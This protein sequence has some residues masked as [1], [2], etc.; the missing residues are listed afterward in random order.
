MTP[1]QE[2]LLDYG[3][4]QLAAGESLETVMAGLRADDAAEILPLLQ[5]VQRIQGLQ[6]AP[7]PAA[8]QRSME[9]MMTERVRLEKVRKSPLEMMRQRG[10]V[11][12]AAMSMVL[13]AVLGLSGLAAGALTLGGMQS[14]QRL[15]GA[16]PSE[17]VR[18]PNGEATL[19]SEMARVG[20]EELGQ[21]LRT[22]AVTGVVFEG[23]VEALDG[24]VWQVAG[25][26]VRL[27]DETEIV[28]GAVAVGAVVDI[29][30][31]TQAEGY[32]LATR[33]TVLTVA[34]VVTPTA[35]PAPTL[36]AMPEAT[37][38]P[39]VTATPVVTE[40]A[41]SVVVGPTA[42]ASETEGP[43]DNGG[44]NSGPGGGSDDDD[45]D[46]AGDDDDDN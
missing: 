25:V 29:E 36:T 10:W 3:L 32:V 34:P 46:D 13:V 23:A 11:L 35:T 26:E 19:T 18:D 4:T 1:E 21:L 42:D 43:D 5:M 15:W 12:A 6:P 16:D 27:D 20:I 14:L 24:R 8:R 41:T 40:A 9:R 44:G 38:T 22:G 39:V 31:V 30:G 17:M 37:V 28:G 2:V 45:D 7:R 33:V